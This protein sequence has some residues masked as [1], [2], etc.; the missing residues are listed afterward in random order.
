MGERGGRKGVVQA[1]GILPA[2]TRLPGPLATKCPKVAITFAP[3]GVNSGSL[4]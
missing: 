1:A 4:G 2:M 3:E